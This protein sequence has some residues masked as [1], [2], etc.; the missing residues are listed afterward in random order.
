MKKILIILFFFII[1]S[2]NNEDIHNGRIPV[3]KAGEKYLYKDEIALILPEKYTSE[4][5]IIK[6]NSYIDIWIKNQLMVQKAEKYLTDE[7]LD[8]ESKIEDYRNS[9]LIHKYKQKFI[10][11]KLD[12][13]ITPE[14]IDEYFLLHSADFRLTKNAVKG[15]FVK[16]LKSDE[17][18]LKV[19][20]WT[21]SSSPIDS[22]KL[23]EYCIENASIYSDFNNDWIYLNTITNDYPFIIDNQADF[24][25]R[26]D[27]ID[28]E[29]ETFYYF[30][31]IKEYKLVNSNSPLIFV[32]EDIKKIILNRREKLMLEELENSI[33]QNALNNGDLEYYND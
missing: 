31:K 26:R 29:D 24:L 1:F 14:E 19:K 16:I 4:D 11:Q 32:K 5:S 13:F 3:A 21:D 20:S 27:F 18:A 23:E 2:C 25:A 17:N 8:I 33:Y 7:Q 28:T 30:L 22:A 6:V 12:T 10:E 15:T 9:L